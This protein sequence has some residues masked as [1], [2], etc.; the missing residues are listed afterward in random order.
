M[1][2]VIKFMFN[3]NSATAVGEDGIRNKKPYIYI[4][5]RNRNGT[6]I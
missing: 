2:C 5:E 6:Y 3:N 1:S 4:K